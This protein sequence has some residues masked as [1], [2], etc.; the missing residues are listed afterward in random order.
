[1][2]STGRLFVA[3]TGS[4]PGRPVSTSI[5][6]RIWRRTREEVFTPAQVA[7]PLAKVPYQLRHTCSGLWL[8]AGVAPDPG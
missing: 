5:Y 3:R 1:M 7:S 4:T 6:T 8:N 2:P